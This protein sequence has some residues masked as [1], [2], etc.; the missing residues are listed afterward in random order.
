MDYLTEAGANVLADRIRKYY[1]G[2]EVV[3]VDE[4]IVW[5]E[6]DGYIWAVR[7]K[8]PEE[9]SSGLIFDCR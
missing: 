3:G 4:V 1:A 8:K 6:F 5:V 7:S 9:W 2:I